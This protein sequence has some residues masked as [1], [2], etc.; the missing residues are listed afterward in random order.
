MPSTALPTTASPLGLPQEA[1]SPAKSGSLADGPVSH[2]GSRSGGIEAPRA[3]DQGFTDLGGL[4]STTR[5]AINQLA[6]LGITKGKSAS[7][8][9]PHGVVTR[10]QMALFL[11][12]FLEVAPVGVGGFDIGDVYSDDDEFRDIG[13]FP[14]V[15]H[16]AILKL[17]EMGVTT[18][19]SATRFS[20]DQPVTR[21]Q[22]A[23]FIT[24]ML[25]HTNARPAG[26]TIQALETT[27]FA[28]T[29]AELVISIRD[30]HHEPVV[31]ASV[32]CSSPS[33]AGRLS[34][35]TGSVT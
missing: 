28:G 22:M 21:A 4:Q 31:D 32:T 24:R 15:T 6:D 9:S 29:D 30:R 23:L 26:I 16:E 18:G 20:P 11:A 3:S 7:T 13:N 27:V 12:R 5:N 33:P 2:E 19:T 35:T 34:R 14:R 1:S 8:F 10:K 25:A 17:F